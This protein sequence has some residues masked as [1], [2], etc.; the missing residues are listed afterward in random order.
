MITTMEKEA[1]LLACLIAD[2][3]LDQHQR[4]LAPKTSD[5]QG[6]LDHGLVQDDRRHL[7]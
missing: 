2:I 3:L 1:A 6:E 5:S 4:S 7:N